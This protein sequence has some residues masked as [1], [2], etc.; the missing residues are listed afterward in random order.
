MQVV[1]LDD[2]YLIAFLR[3]GGADRLLI[4]ANLSEHRVM[5]P[6]A[7]TLRQAGAARFASLT[8]GRELDTTAGLA[9]EPYGFMVLRPLVS[10]AA[11]R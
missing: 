8:E 9:V 3:R 7:T 4:V 6:G 10:G 1:R 5:V 11:P 2:R